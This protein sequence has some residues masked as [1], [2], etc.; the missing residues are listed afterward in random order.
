MKTK[1]YFA[2]AF[3]AYFFFLI[4]SLPAK[5]VIEMLTADR[6]DIEIDTIRG[7]LWNGKAERVVIDSTYQLNKVRWNTKLWRIIFGELV[8]DVNAVFEKQNVSALIGISV[9]GNISAQ[10]IHARIDAETLSDLAEIP[11][12][13]LEGLISVDLDTLHWQQGEIPIASGKIFWQDAL[14]TVAETVQ[15]GNVLIQLV[16]HDENQMQATISNQGGNLKTDGTATLDSL[17]NYKVSL[18]LTPS[19]SSSKN[20]TDSLNIFAKK[21]KNG[22]FLV[23]YDGQLDLPQ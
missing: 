21:Q 4:A 13:Q 6:D 7:S 14:L 20:L 12:A 10:N 8:L 17:A 23:K 2:I 15:L 1:Y 5:P 11:L 22:S 19:S 3:I 9:L 18:V 16:E